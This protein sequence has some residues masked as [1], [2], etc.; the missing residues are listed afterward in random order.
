MAGTQ[1]PASILINEIG[2]MSEFVGPSHLPIGVIIIIVIISNIMY[3][4]F[5]FIF[6]VEI[7]PTYKPHEYEV[8]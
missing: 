6:S 2:N 7:K 5:L 3:C 1:T 4:Y 8:Y